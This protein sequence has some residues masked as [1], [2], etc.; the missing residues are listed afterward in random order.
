MVVPPPISAIG[1]LPVCCSQY[2]HMICTIDAD[3]QRGRGAVEADI[4]D[5]LALGGQRIQRLRV[6]NLMDEAALLQHIQKIRF[7]SSHLCATLIILISRYFQRIAE[8]A[9]NRLPPAA[10]AVAL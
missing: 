5:E 4:G 7:K 10:R 3:V 1:L 2:R 6:G 8:P 9:R